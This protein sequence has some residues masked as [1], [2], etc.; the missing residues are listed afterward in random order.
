MKTIAEEI[1]ELR[2]MMVPTLVERYR[3]LWGREP[4][5]K[6]RTWLWKRCAWK[7][8]EQRLG[9]LST[10]A[11]RRLE[12]LIAEIDL[13]I[14]E[15]QQTVTGALPSPTRAPQHQVG[16]VFSRTWKGREVRTVAVEG[17]YEYE[18]TF[19]HRCRLRPARGA[20]LFWLH[21]TA[22]RHLAGRHRDQQRHRA[23]GSD[24]HRAGR[25]WP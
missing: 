12:E 20:L 17:G 16:T 8:Q 15:R 22:G 7:V 11:K 21:D 6:N 4:K 10:V 24:P 23:L 19:T 2:G 25:E 18:G 1:A 5:V 3:K 13:P 9:G 14:G